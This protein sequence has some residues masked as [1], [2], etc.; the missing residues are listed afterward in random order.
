MK[1]RI[2]TLVAL[3]ILIFQTELLKAQPQAPDSLWS[4]ISWWDNEKCYAISQAPDGGYIFAGHTAISSGQG[5]WD[6]KLVKTDPVGIPIRIDTYGTDNIDYCYDMQVT[7]DGGCILAGN[8][9][10]FALSY[11]VM[12]V[13][14][15]TEGDSLWYREYGGSNAEYCYSVQETTDGGYVLGGKTAS[16]GAGS[17]DFWLVK[18]D[19]SGDSIWSRTYG[20]TGHDAC[21]S[22]KQTSDGGYILAG[23]RSEPGSADDDFLL[24][25]TDDAGNM[26]WSQVY[27]GNSYDYCMSVIECSQGGYVL[28]G[29]TM[30]YSV[31]NFD[32]WLIKTDAF[33]NHEWDHTYG[34]GDIDKCKR[35]MELNN[36]GYVLAGYSESFGAGEYDYWL[37]RTD[38]FGEMLWDK[39]FG[40]DQIDECNDFLQTPDGGFVLAGH[41]RS[42]GGIQNTNFLVGTTAEG[43]PDNLSIIATPVNPPIV[44]PANGGSFGFNVTIE[45]FGQVTLSTQVWTMATLPNGNEI[46]PVLG[47]AELTVLGSSMVS[48]DLTQN[49]PGRAPSGDYSYG[50]YLG[51][52]PDAVWDDDNFNFSKAEGV[53]S[54]NSV[55]NWDCTELTNYNTD[56]LK[57]DT[58]SLLSV[59]P[60]PFNSAVRIE[61]E[62]A[63][64][65]E[66]KLVLYDVSGREVEE[67]FR[68][69]KE[70]GYYS[71][72]YRGEGLASGI[73]FVRF[74]NNQFKNSV[75]VV[76]LK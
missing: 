56:V 58:Y 49:V 32:Y 18:T 20:D 22:V 66:V 36:G 37:V 60:N 52:Y 17:Y 15:D 4:S 2:S 33:G 70:A 64:A 65:G 62:V 51:V 48:Y 53:C 42:Y 74:E 47:P 3:L 45:N 38:E 76:Y 73:Y 40:G 69:W 12:L 14:T 10:S 6:F 1:M 72:D 75:K 57:P 16:F 68:G 24:I 19:A 11:N 41:S 43:N 61:Y 34:G 67:I 13:K 5:S 8:T 50:A 31:G 21:H 39:T 23:Y 55:S 7:A 35:V 46:G 63:N 30:S 54:P 28:A 25:K 26:M 44:I 29:H 59:Y 71:S 27:G 9:G